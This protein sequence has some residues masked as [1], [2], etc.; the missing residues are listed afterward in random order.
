MAFG[1]TYGAQEPL[2]YLTFDLDTLGLDVFS[3]YHGD[4]KAS[5]EV[6]STSCNSV[7]PIARISAPRLS[8]CA[9]TY[10]AGI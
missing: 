3:G 6:L 7:A 10:A 2:A 4:A 5:I 8:S 9:T 1:T